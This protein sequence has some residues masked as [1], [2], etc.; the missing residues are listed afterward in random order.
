[1]VLNAPVHRSAVAIDGECQL[2][3]MKVSCAETTVHAICCRIHQ[4]GFFKILIFCGHGGE[5]VI[6]M[7]SVSVTVVVVHPS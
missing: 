2:A 7:T 5:R 4:A 1:M 6:L 3:T